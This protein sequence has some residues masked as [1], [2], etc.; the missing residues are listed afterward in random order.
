MLHPRS[1]QPQ[2]PCLP[3]PEPPT[4]RPP[5]G[6]LH[7][8]LNVQDLQ[9]RPGGG[10]EQV[11]RPGTCSGEAGAGKA[12]APADSF[13]MC[14]LACAGRRFV[15]P[16]RCMARDSSHAL[17]A[18]ATAAPSRPNRPVDAGPRGEHAG[19]PSKAAERWCSRCPP[20]GHA[21][22]LAGDGA[23]QV[24]RQLRGAALNR[25]VVVDLLVRGCTGSRGFQ[26]EVPGLA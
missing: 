9:G 14:D 26:R 11:T 22:L 5:R 7:R 15:M 1:W 24:G 18:L 25:D 10:W 20:M 8:I 12:A 21:H 16:P 17:N 3:C 6:I 4:A 2:C 19:M 13:D 23:T